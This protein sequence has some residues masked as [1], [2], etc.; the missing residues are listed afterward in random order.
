MM[1]VPS[2]KSYDVAVTVANPGVLIDVAVHRDKD[3]G[4][5]Q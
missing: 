2:G 4:N 1:V 5:I 3:T